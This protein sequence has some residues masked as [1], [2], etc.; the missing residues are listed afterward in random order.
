MGPVV[1]LQ[2]E[3][4]LRWYAFLGLISATGREKS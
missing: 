4:S 3:S 1:E 2:M